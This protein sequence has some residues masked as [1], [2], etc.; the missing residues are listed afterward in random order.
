VRSLRDR[1][2]QG[3]DASVIG[4]VVAWRPGFGFIRSEGE[5]KD[6]WVHYSAIQGLPVDRRQLSIGQRVEFEMVRSCR[7]PQAANVRILSDSGEKPRRVKLTPDQ[8]QS[9][10]IILGSGMGKR[11]KIEWVDRYARQGY[12]YEEILERAKVNLTGEL[13]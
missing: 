6:V 12:S 7:G 1:A 8:R 4:R 3:G 9:I 5:F 2:E 11:E 10:D 13:R